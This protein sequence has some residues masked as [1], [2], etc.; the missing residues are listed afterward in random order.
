MNSNG[1]TGWSAAWTPCGTAWDVV[2]TPV[3]S[4]VNA[5]GGTSA[6]AN[7]FRTF[8][9][10]STDNS[11][12]YIKVRAAQSNLLQSFDIS[13]VA[14]GDTAVAFQLRTTG[15]I[16]VYDNTTLTNQGAYSADTNYLITIKTIPST[17]S[18]T[19]TIDSGT[20]SSTYAMKSFGSFD[21]TPGLDKFGASILGSGSFFIDD[22]GVAPAAASTPAIFN[23]ILFE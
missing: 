20:E 3:I 10:D 9:I 18:F 23:I 17:E 1:G 22:I 15:Q 16:A 7:C 8:T 5:A 21:F 14:A 4:G 6:E 13:N 19:I 11:K 12:F 2:T